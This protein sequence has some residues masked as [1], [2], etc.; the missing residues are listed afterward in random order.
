MGSPDW[1]RQFEIARAG[2]DPAG[3]LVGD[4]VGVGHAHGEPVTATLEV[5]PVLDGTQLQVRERVG[6]HED[7]S[8]YRFDIATGQLRVVH[9]MAPALVAEYAV[10][11]TG[12][13]LVWVTAPAAPTVVW[14]YDPL[15][16]AVTSEV[17]WPDQRVAEVKLRYTRAAP[18]AA[19]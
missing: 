18:S 9:L 14:T 3:V 7:I 19:P 4:W 15:S 13:G 17:F 1:E 11:L 8:F 5:R 6:G 12:D 2:L 16:D 10:E